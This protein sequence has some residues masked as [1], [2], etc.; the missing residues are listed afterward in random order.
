MHGGDTQSTEST[1]VG[2]GL[3]A[4]ETGLKLLKEL[5]DQHEV[6]PRLVESVGVHS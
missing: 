2:V 5:I 3:E 6:S 4:A 1:H